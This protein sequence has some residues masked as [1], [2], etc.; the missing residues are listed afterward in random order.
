M[1]YGYMFNPYLSREQDP[2]PRILAGVD[3]DNLDDEPG[4]RLV[5]PCNNIK[6]NLMSA[7]AM[8]ATD[9]SQ[10]EYGLSETF[11]EAPDPGLR[12]NGFGKVTLPLAED[13]A[14]QLVR[15][16]HRAPFGRREQTVVD[17]EVRDTWEINADQ[18]SFENP[19]WQTWFKSVVVDNVAKK[20]GVTSISGLELYKL[21]LYQEGSHFLPHQ[22]T[23]KSPGMVA[24]II[25]VL[26]SKFEGG[27]VH[28]S[29]QGR[30]KILDIAE[31]SAS[32]TSILAWYSDVR[33]GVK[34]I[35]SGY[36]LALSYNLIIPT[37]VPRPDIPGNS[38][39]IAAVR[40]VLLSWKQSFDATT[41]LKLACVLDHQYSLHGLQNGVFRGAD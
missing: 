8:G 12:V 10:S 22:D 1:N 3:A 18:I 16:C 38:K 36:R 17:Q 41:P 37:G 15:V 35:T 2:H 13:K 33:H 14:R 19:L 9:S 31:H 32:A 7:L 24:T 5:N 6:Q 26:P 23:E 25:V 34:P 28:L 39:M 4:E 30:R 11:Q 40:H 27:Q 21:L 20:L 29:H